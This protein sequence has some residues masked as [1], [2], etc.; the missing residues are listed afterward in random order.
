MFDSACR[1]MSRTEAAQGERA[2]LRQFQAQPAPDAPPVGNARYWEE[3]HANDLAEM[4][5]E[6]AVEIENLSDPANPVAVRLRAWARCLASLQGQ[7]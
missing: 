3:R 1:M 2:H 7:E 6:A 4:F 5:S